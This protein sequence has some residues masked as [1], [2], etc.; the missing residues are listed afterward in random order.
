MGGEGKGEKGV[1]GKGKVR[2]GWDGI[3]TA[4]T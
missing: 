2:R 4:C 1:G 3:G